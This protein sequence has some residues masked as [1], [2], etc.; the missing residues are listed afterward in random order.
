MPRDNSDDSSDNP[1]EPLAI[2]TLPPM[3][4]SDQRIMAALSLI[5]RDNTVRPSLEAVADAAGLS[6]FHFNR[7]FADTMGETIG[8]YIRRT[9]LDWAA[10]AVIRTNAS[11]L[12]TALRSGYASQEAFTR[13]FIRQFN[14]T[15]GGMRTAAAAAIPVPRLIDRERAKL[16]RPYWQEELPL[17]GTRFYGSYQMVPLFWRRFARQLQDL[18]FLLD[19]AQAIGILL[20]DPS[21]TG[22]G[23]V[24]YDCCVVDR[25]YPPH[26]VKAPL[27]RRKAHGSQF[28]RVPI[29][30][31]N[32]D[33]RQTVRSVCIAWVQVHRK[34]FSDSPAY[35]LY[36]APPWTHEDWFNLSYL[37]PIA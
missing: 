36:D 21:I 19:H 2:R 10:S 1:G 22:P 17:I 37:V 35:E 13:A 4:L 20:D 8:A 15:P 34:R 25:G 29:E 28:A 7:R 5:E 11:L 30:G 33:V 26:L 12:D 18:G 14:V 9:R 3:I 6:L 16:V 27:W 31:R 23:L 32:L 24:R